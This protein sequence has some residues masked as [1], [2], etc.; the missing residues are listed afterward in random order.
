MNQFIRNENPKDNIDINRKLILEDE[1][2]LLILDMQEKLIRN[3]KDNQLLVFNINKLINTC[4][5]LNVS[6]GR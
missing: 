6:C 1:T 2:L 4:N 5:L 3:I